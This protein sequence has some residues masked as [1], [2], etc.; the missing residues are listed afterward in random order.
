M[1]GSHAQRQLLGA[2]GEDYLNVF[3]FLR[4]FISDPGWIVTILKFSLNWFLRL[5]ATQRS[6]VSR[7][8]YY[9]RLSLDEVI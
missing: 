1:A 2:G 5:K 8:P 9:L 3:F 7:L 4:P 6:L